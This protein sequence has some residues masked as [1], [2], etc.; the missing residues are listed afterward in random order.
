MNMCGVAALPMNREGKNA[1]SSAVYKYHFLGPNDAGKKGLA[2]TLPRVGLSKSRRT[3]LTTCVQL[4]TAFAW[5]AGHLPWLLGPFCWKPGPESVKAEDQDRLETTERHWLR[6][7]SDWQRNTIGTISLKTL[8]T[9][10]YLH[11]HT[12]QEV[13]IGYGH[14]EQEGDCGVN[15][16]CWVFTFGHPLRLPPTLFLPLHH[17]QT[18]GQ[19]SEII[20]DVRYTASRQEGN[21]SVLF[22]GNCLLCSDNV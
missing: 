8:L 7:H 21:N 12:P 4:E 13:L 14:I 18:M 9:F 2:K 1:T 19:T 22:A 15:V 3:I 16:V 10:N 17:P 5:I 20:R 6:P 11:T